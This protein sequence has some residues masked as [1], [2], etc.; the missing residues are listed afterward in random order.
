[1][2]LIV[3]LLLISILFTSAVQGYLAWFSC[4]NLRTFSL[5]SM[6]M[7]RIG[8]CGHVLEDNL[9]FLPDIAMKHWALV[10]RHKN[11]NDHST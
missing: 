9:H 2:F 11:T 3:H 6:S 5:H 10:Q 8:S 1:M 7:Y 4:N